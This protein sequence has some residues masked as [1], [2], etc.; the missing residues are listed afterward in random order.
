M[1]TELLKRE[2]RRSDPYIWGII[3]VL[4]I[5]SIVEGYSAV[6][7]EIHG[8]DIYSPMIEHLRF[9]LLGLGVTYMVS[10]FPL[11]VFRALTFLAIPAAFFL[12]VSILCWGDMI[13]G[14]KR[15]I[16]LLGV[17]VQGSEVAKI[18]IVLAMAFILAKYQIRRG[19]N[20]KGVIWVVLLATIFGGLLITQGLTNAILFFGISICMML[21]GGVEFHKL[22]AVFVVY[23]V[24]GLAGMQ[25]KDMYDDYIAQKA[26][27]A[28][29][30]QLQGSASI[31]TAPK[32]K[33]RSGTWQS[34]LD[35]FFDSIPEYRQPTTSK[36]L[37]EH[38][39]AMAMAHGGL[40]GVG[41]GN[42]RETSR[43]PLAFSDYIYAIIIEDLGLIFGGLLVLFA[44]LMILA[45]AGIIARRCTRAYPAL[46]VMGMAVMIVLQALFNMAI[47]VGV[48]PVS[49]QPLPLISRGGTS[50]LMMSFAFGVILSVSRYGVNHNGDQI[51]AVKETDLPDDLQAAN[52]TNL[53]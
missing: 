25:V 39:A 32:V 38:R 27:K 2:K 15:T 9:L 5:I 7:R 44:Y 20:M 16:R 21:I 18:T 19:V 45:R 31:A 35:D 22:F 36:N 33:T 47:V 6:S 49:G 42:S 23:A 34:R 40:T 13:N 53:A 10:Y 26:A 14:A 52:P 30:E 17:S 12:L 4:Y 24:L 29:V 51:K 46:L 1:E 11:K 8:N 28:Q 3:I 41:P 37:Q 48:F 43:L 50:I